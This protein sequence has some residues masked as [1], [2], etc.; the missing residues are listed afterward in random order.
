[1]GNSCGQTGGGSQQE[2][3]LQFWR[4]WYHGTVFHVILG[5][6]R[7]S[8]C[9]TGNRTVDVRGLLEEPMCQRVEARAG[10]SEKRLM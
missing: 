1:M 4:R 7:C 3:W 5:Y 6:G 8:C 2:A 10:W 9:G